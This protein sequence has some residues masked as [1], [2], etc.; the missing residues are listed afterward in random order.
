MS[1]LQEEAQENNITPC[2]FLGY[3]LHKENYVKDRAIPTVG[4]QLLAWMRVS[5]CCH[6]TNLV[7]P[8]TQV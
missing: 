6:N 8:A 7:I 3:L 4:I 1:L 2:Q 5:T